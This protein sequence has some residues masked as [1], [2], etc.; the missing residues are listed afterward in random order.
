M[1]NIEK[2]GFD[3]D[4]GQGFVDFPREGRNFLRGNFYSNYE[5]IKISTQKEDRNWKIMDQKG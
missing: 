5:I 4:L 1:P 3:F 2:S